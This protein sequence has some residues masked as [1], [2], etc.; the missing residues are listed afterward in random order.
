[1]RETHRPLRG[2]APSRCQ[3]A[4][5][6]S[7]RRVLSPHVAAWPREERPRPP[8]L[9]GRTPALR[10]RSQQE[11]TACGRQV[12]GPR[13]ASVPP[14]ER[15]VPAG[16]TRSCGQ[17]RVQRRGQRKRASEAERKD[18]REAARGPSGREGPVRPAPRKTLSPSAH[19]EVQAAGERVGGTGGGPGVR[20]QGRASRATPS[21]WAGSAH[22]PAAPESDSGRQRHRERPAGTPDSGAQADRGRRHTPGL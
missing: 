20:G 9:G 18:R 12:P 3:G 19:A 7:T 11:A 1:M 22:L 21:P 4:G 17:P 10:F 2:D 6:T 15:Y 13:G 16:V 5:G 14:A 8:A